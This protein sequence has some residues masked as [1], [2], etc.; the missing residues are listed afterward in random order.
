M[1]DFFL[2]TIQSNDQIT[3]NDIDITLKWIRIPQG[4]NRIKIVDAQ[5][6]ATKKQSIV[7]IHNSDNL[8]MARAIVVCYWKHSTEV[9]QKKIYKYQY[10]VN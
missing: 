7:E 4:G 10:L 1:I 6:A 5:M 8:C 2:T 3:L 9:N